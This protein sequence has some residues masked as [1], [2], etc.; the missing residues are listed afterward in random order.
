M[1]F[2]NLIKTDTEYVQCN[3]VLLLY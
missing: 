1:V 3:C 2:V